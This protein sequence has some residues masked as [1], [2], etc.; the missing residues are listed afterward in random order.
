MRSNAADCISRESAYHIAKAIYHL[1]QC[2]E[3]FISKGHFSELLP[4]LLN[5]IYL[6]RIRRDKKELYIIRYNE[7]SCLVPCRTVTAQKNH[8]SRK[9]LRQLFQKDIHTGCIAVG[10]DQKTGV[11]CQRFYCTIRIAVFSDMMTRHRGTNA[12][13]TPTVFG[14]ID[15]PE[16]CFVLE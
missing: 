9:L 15:S 1:R 7:V 13:L 4:N 14:L 16:A 3:D 11:A 6:R 12:L 10:H 5:R 2:R 8:V